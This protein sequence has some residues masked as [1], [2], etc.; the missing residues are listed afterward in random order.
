MKDK[1]NPHRIDVVQPLCKFTDNKTQQ[2]DNKPS[3]NQ[4]SSLAGNRT[5]I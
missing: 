1:K 2:T 3:K 4:H 5:R